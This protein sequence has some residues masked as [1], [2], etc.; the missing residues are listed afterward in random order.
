LKLCTN[1][2]LIDSIRDALSQSERTKKELKNKEI[3]NFSPNQNSINDSQSNFNPEK[4][5]TH[6]KFNNNFL[7]KN[8]K[9]DNNQINDKRFL[10]KK[11]RRSD[12]SNDY[13][14]EKTNANFSNDNFNPHAAD[15][16][17]YKKKN[18][19]NQN[20]NHAVEFNKNNFHNYQSEDKNF[21]QNK[22][23]EPKSFIKPNQNFYQNDEYNRNFN[24]HGN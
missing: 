3:V 2:S 4:F 10:N 15:N 24:R 19:Y 12:A 22:N 17:D 7:Q 21:N 8:N 1:D 6:Q 14:N 9:N 20:Y 13:Q 16:I 5:D 18:F 11:Y 23:F